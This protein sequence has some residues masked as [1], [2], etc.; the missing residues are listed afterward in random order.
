MVIGINGTRSTGR[1]SI[2]AMTRSRL[3][4]ARDSTDKLAVWLPR[5]WDEAPP[6]PDA[7]TTASIFWRTPDRFATQHEQTNRP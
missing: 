2:W 4:M 6:K 1:F 5:F 3:F 7:A